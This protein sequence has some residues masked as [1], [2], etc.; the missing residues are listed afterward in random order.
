[1]NRRRGI[2][3]LALFLAVWLIPGTAMADPPDND[4]IANAVVIDPAALPYQEVL[5]TSMATMSAEELAIA[6][7]CQGPPGYAAGVWYS[8]TPT[9]DMQLRLSAEGSDYGVG[10][11]IYTGGPDA[12]MLEGCAPFDVDFPVPAGLTIHILVID[13]QGAGPESNGGTLHLSVTDAGTEICPGLFSNGQIVNSGGNLIMGTE[14]DDVLE[15]TRG[16]DIII[17]LDGHDTIH[18][19]RGDDVLIGCDGDD[20][21]DGGPGNDDIHGDAFGYFGNPNYEG[22]GNDFVEGR[23]G[24]DSI[25]G[26]AGDDVLR[27]G[28]GDDFVVGHQGEDLVKG[29]RGDDVLLGGF[30]DDRVEGHKGNDFVNGGWGNDFLKAGRGDDF[31]HGAPPAFGPGDDDPEPDAIDEC[32]GGPGADG[33]VFCEIVRGVPS[34]PAGVLQYPSLQRF[35]TQYTSR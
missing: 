29:H 4:D 1:M 14:G 18:G 9:A 13:D 17:G 34:P 3:V 25:S 33:A 31:L 10:F 30:G 5:D 28:F 19:L 8:F 15:G 32:L 6:Q 11:L 2:L 22:G 16:R 35:T 24:H 21:I 26:G 23:G 7:Q 12:P 20:H 27:G